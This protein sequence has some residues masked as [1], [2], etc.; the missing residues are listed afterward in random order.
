MVTNYFFGGEQKIEMTSNTFILCAGVPQRTGMSQRQYARQ[1]RRWS[2]WKSDELRFS[3]PGVYKGQKWNFVDDTPKLAHYWCLGDQL[4]QC[5]HDRFSSSF[6]QGRYRRWA[7]RPSFSDVSRDVAMATNFRGKL[8]KLVNSYSFVAMALRNWLEYCNPDR[9]VNSGDY[10]TIS[11]KNLLNFGPVTPEFIRLNCVQQA[12]ISTRVSLTEFT[13]GGTDRLLR[14][15][16][17]TTIH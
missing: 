8:E 4:S 12:S 11:F 13:R 16:V 3:N 7:I 2:L 9:R 17:V 14:W 5:L 6:Q 1:Q 10:L 15:S